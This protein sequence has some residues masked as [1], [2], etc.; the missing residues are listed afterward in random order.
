[1]ADRFRSCASNYYFTENFFERLD[2]LHV[3]SCRG[4]PAQPFRDLILRLDSLVRVLVGKFV[5][6]GIAKRNI[7]IKRIKSSLDY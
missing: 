6:N 4:R 7:F 2:Y 3:T 5:K 1:M